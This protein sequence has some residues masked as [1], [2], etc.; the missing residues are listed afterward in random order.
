MCPL[1]FIGLL[2]EKVLQERQKSGHQIRGATNLL[3]SMEG[4][5]MKE[6]SLLLQRIELIKHCNTLV[7]NKVKMMK[8]ADFTTHISVIQES[9]FAL[10]FDLRCQILERQVDDSM[11]DCVSETSREKSLPLGI[12]LLAM[13]CP[14]GQVDDTIDDLNLTGTNI[15]ATLEDELRKKLGNVEPQELSA[16]TARSYEALAKCLV[17]AFGCN[18]FFDVMASP[19]AAANKYK[20]QFI[21]ERFLT[22]WRRR[23]SADRLP[24]PVE[25]ACARIHAVVMALS[26]LLGSVPGEFG[27][28]VAHVNTLVKYKGNDVMESLF[29]DQLLKNDYWRKLWDELLAKGSASLEAMPDIDRL[30]AGL[31]NADGVAEDILQES[32]LKL[33]GYRKTLRS[34][35]LTKIE[36]LLGPAVKQTAEALLAG[37]GAVEGE[38]GIFI[39]SALSGLNL[40]AD[41]PG[42]LGLIGKLQKIRVKASGALAKQDLCLLCSKCPTTFEAEFVCDEFGL[43]RAQGLE[44]LQGDRV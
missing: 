21:C 34:A 18:T 30:I 32:V 35:V 26:C 37:G 1:C 16:L 3:Q 8:R 23:Q 27:A 38:T 7:F 4:K 41:T 6:A 28:S 14:W 10:S 25:K 5:K 29:R 15:L 33:P 31:S 44:Q 9:G 20:L 11:F 43:D 17:S 12:K 42:S 36:G 13:I 22:E 39:D 2:P 19:K 40:F 24:D